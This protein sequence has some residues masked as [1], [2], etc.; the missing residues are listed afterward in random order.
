[1]Q[2]TASTAKAAEREL[3]TK[4]AGRTHFRPSALSLTAD[5]SFHDLVGYWLADLEVDHQGAL[6]WE[7]ASADGRESPSCSTVRVGLKPPSDW[8]SWTRCIWSW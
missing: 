4:L 7:A 2:A 6:S 3:K 8:K 1:V 5:S